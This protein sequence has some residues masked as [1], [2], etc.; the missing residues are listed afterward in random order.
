MP[1]A[2]R[3]IVVSAQERIGGSAAAFTGCTPAFQNNSGF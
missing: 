1:G 3:K 2:H